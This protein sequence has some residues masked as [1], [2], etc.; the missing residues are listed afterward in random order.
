MAARAR[1][2]WAGPLIDRDADRDRMRCVFCCK[3]W[4]GA[5]QGTFLLP[6][7]LKVAVCAQKCPAATDAA[8]G[9]KRSARAPPLDVWSTPSPTRAPQA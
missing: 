3:G 6:P 1:G 5:T 9:R 2:V 8:M 4:G 7:K